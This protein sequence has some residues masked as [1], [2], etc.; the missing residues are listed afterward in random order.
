MY[1]CSWNIISQLWSV[2]CYMGSHSVTFYPTQVNT[3]H[4]HLSQTGRQKAEF[5]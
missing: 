5:T 3:P 2:T 1:S 4:L